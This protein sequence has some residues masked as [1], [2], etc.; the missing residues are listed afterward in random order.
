MRCSFVND[1]NKL[2]FKQFRKKCSINNFES[3]LQILRTATYKVRVYVISGGKRIKNSTPV[4]YNQSLLRSYIRVRCKC[5][6]HIIYAF[7]KNFCLALS[8]EYVIL[9]LCYTLVFSQRGLEKIIQSQ[10]KHVD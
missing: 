3:Q 1:I 8:N 10:I 2:A 7:E 9:V 4:R 6:I 5:G